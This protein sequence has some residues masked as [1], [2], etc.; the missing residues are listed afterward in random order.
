VSGETIRLPIS[1]G[2][3]VDFLHV[4]YIKENCRCLTLCLSYCG[5]VGGSLLISLAFL[6]FH[7]LK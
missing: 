1:L 4:M 7:K 2:L 5:Q 6:V 3:A